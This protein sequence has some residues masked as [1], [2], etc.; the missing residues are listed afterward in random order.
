MEPKVKVTEK[1]RE[2]LKDVIDKPGTDIADK[3]QI[4]CVI[5]ENFTNVPINLVLKAW[6]QKKKGSIFVHHMIIAF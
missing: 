2:L 3:K 5:D 6:K 1:I 4:E